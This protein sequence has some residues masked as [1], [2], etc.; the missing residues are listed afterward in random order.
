MRALLVNPWIYDFACFD[1]FSKPIGFLKIARILQDLG[2]KLDYIDCLDRL[3]PA[4]RRF[5]SKDQ[6]FGCGNYYSE[7]VQKPSIFKGVPRYYKRYGMPPSIFKKLL[8]RFKRPDVILVTSGMTYW[9]KGVFEAIDTL[10]SAFK[11]VPI[12]L[13]GVYASLC[14]GHTRKF[15]GADF[16]VKGNRIEGFLAILNMIFGKDF[17]LKQDYHKVFPL[18]ELYPRLNYVSLRSSSGCPFRCS[19]CGWYLLDD[20]FYRLPCEEV[21]HQIRYFYRRFKVKNFAFYDD[22]LLYQPQEHIKPLLRLIIKSKLNL[23]FHTPNGLNAVFIDKEL[24]LLLKRAGFTQVRLGLETASPQL[25]IA[26]G[27]KIDNVTIKRAIMFLK[28]AGFAAGEIAVYLLIGLVNQTFEQIQE[29][30]LFA[31]SLGVKVYL[32]EYSPIPGTLDYQRAGLSENLDPLWH[33]NSVFPLYKGID[34]Y[35]SL[36]RLKD[37]NHRLNNK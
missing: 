16:V 31:H 14:F 8:Q 10:K 27:G 33:N 29:S 25:Q 1:L 4:M 18:Y 12:I 36:Q 32:E 35:L 37:L 26:T 9:Y 7:I 19:Y 30:I 11:G 6:L 20:G 5:K 22:A 28:E 21:I 17:S 24:A 2:F 34:N 13:G 23:N 15:S 3:H